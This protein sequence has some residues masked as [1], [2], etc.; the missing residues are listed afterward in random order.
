[1]ICN[2]L[3]S[4]LSLACVA[5]TLV[6]T[7]ASATAGGGELGW[8]GNGPSAS[9]ADG[10]GG[11]EFKPDPPVPPA[12][13]DHLLPPPTGWDPVPAT[14]PGTDMDAGSWIDMAQGLQGSFG[15]PGLSWCI[16]PFTPG[17]GALWISGGLP[18]ASI[19]LI[20]GF[21][22]VSLP[23]RGGVLVPRPDIV[24]SGFVLGSDGSLLIPV[25]SDP[26]A[27][28]TLLFLQAWIADPAGPELLAS[29]NGIALLAL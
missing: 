28:P 13:T 21:D 8:G 6:L 7:S 15:V 24:L 12:P 5:V 25:L 9:G 10:V 3:G 4:M 26:N 1:M 20:V 2:R 14:P 22:S 16:N 27:P 29:T 17:L 23:F 18:N 11:I 19:W